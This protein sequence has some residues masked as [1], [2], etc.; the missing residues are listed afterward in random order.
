MLGLLPKVTQLINDRACLTL[1]CF[2]CKIWGKGPC[3]PSVKTPGVPRQMAGNDLAN[4]PVLM[5]LSRPMGF[6]AT[7]GRGPLLLAP[8]PAHYSGVVLQG[9]TSPTGDGTVLGS[10]CPRSCSLQGGSRSPWGL[11]GPLETSGAT[12]TL[13]PPLQ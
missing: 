2:I 5:G 7:W 8:P 10:C 11:Q 3:H 1:S 6:R 13:P 4:H 9:S 12:L